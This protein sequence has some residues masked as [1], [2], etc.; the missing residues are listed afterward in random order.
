MPLG[1]LIYIDSASILTPTVTKQKSL[2]TSGG[3]IIEEEQAT[4]KLSEKKLSSTQ[5]LHRDRVIG[6]SGEGDQ[7]K[8]RW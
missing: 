4:D 8:G 7:R 2:D 6:G 5:S 1:G 3:T